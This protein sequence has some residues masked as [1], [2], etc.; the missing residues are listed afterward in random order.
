MT[1]VIHHLQLVV[2]K[3]ID[4]DKAVSKVERINSKL[5]LQMHMHPIPM[6]LVLGLYVFNSIS[7]L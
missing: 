2:A 1:H 3:C 6:T 7:W 5:V 4:E